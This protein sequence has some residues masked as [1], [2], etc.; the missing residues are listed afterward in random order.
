MAK[1]V[2]TIG[3]PTHIKQSASLQSRQLLSKDSL[4]LAA[5]VLVAVAFAVGL[6]QQVGLNIVLAATVGGLVF[7]ILFS[8]HYIIVHVSATDVLAPRVSSLE[9]VVANIARDMGRVDD[10]AKDIAG[11]RS[12][13][14]RIESL[15]SQLQ[16]G[17]YGEA[18]QARDEM[19]QLLNQEISRLE[20]QMQKMKMEFAH[21]NEQNKIRLKS[22]LNVIEKLV[23]QMGVGLPLANDGQMLH[24]SL[25]TTHG[26]DG[27]LSP[28]G[29][30]PQLLPQ[31]NAQHDLPHMP[32]QMTPQRIMQKPNLPKRLM[33]PMDDHRMPKVADHPT[34]AHSQAFTEGFSGSQ[35]EA[36][37]PFKFNQVHQDS[38]GATHIQNRG[39]QTLLPHFSD[40][41]LHRSQEDRHNTHNTTLPLQGHS[42]VSDTRTTQIEP[43]PR[44]HVKSLRSHTEPQ[45]QNTV[46]SVKH[47]NLHVPNLSLK[48]LSQP[49]TQNTAQ[50]ETSRSPNA[51]PGHV[52]LGSGQEMGSGLAN[53]PGQS[54]L[55]SPTEQQVGAV[56]PQQPSFQNSHD[57]THNVSPQSAAEAPMLVPVPAPVSMSFASTQA[58]HT[59]HHELD[60]LGH[61]RPEN[62]QSVQDRHDA[63]IGSGQNFEETANYENPALQAAHNDL[64]RE[65]FD[66]IRNAIENNRV[67][68]FLQPVVTL[69]QR[70]VCY[71]EA[72]TRIRGATGELIL[73]ANYI[74][75]AERE[76][77]MPIIDNIMLY[78]SVQ[79]IR[80]LSER[81]SARG[82]FCNISHYSLLDAEFFAEFIEFMEHNKSLN[83]VLY[84]DFSQH[85]FQNSST[86][87]HESM[88]TLAGLGFKFCLDHVQDLNLD[89]ASLE[90]RGFGFIRIAANIL[91]NG[92]AKANS[93]IHAADMQSYLE[94]FNM[95]LIVE[96][97]EDERTLAQLSSFGIKLGQGYL[98]S[99]PRPVR[100][101]IFKGHPA[102]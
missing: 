52:T 23:R 41:A 42:G 27:S 66:L 86:V 4:I 21:I 28:Q 92:M 5:I 50:H 71:Y 97:V 24:N 22:E 43:S 64:D 12:T 78:R 102:S 89:F 48:H 53:D 65:M 19:S 75:L 68:L 8:L 6:Y 77:V 44:E 34:G 62:S 69:P 63:H 98:F 59:P 7:F 3:A 83:E 67:D 87:E 51:H 37:A 49:D 79:V 40:P 46:Q 57:G 16:L 84:F 11:F 31:S 15:H 74:P 33:P 54:F 80:R 45:S 36:E 20:T 9:R 38:N 2:A 99:E 1:R 14:E 35:D 101:E 76:G 26:T 47:P 95:R 70:D 29:G 94:R 96:K 56:A 85:M 61:G 93:R 88:N 10:L 58:G 73:P 91:L 55:Q 13:C 25:R 17:G 30:Y 100:A 39:S 82:L 32:M 72:L 81:K 90:K 60:L 18:L